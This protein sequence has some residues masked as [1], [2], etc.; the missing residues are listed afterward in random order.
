MTHLQI[1]RPIVKNLIFGYGLQNASFYTELKFD[2]DPPQKGNIN[3]SERKKKKRNEKH[4][5][6][7]RVA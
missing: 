3:E 2:N 6:H 4:F 7:D 5:L 1:Y